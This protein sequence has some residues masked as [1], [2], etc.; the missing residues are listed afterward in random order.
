MNNLDENVYDV[1]IVGAGLS[2]TSAGY[3]LTKRVKNLKILFIEAKDRVGGRTQT[4]SLKSANGTSRWDIGGQWC[5][6]SQKNLLA[7]LNE[8]NVETYRQYDTGKKMLESNGYESFF[9][10]VSN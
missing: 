8:L 3:F 6:E 4:I 7:L 1:I 5:G 9:L 10:S 2:G